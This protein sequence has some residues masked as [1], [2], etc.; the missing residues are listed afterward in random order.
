MVDQK[1]LYLK[2]LGI[3]EKDTVGLF[4]EKNIDLIV[5][6]LAVLKTGSA[7]TLLKKDISDKCKEYLKNEMPVRQSNQYLR[8]H[9]SHRCQTVEPWAKS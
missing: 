6:I 4:F 5:D 7:F 1:A 9:A 2:S 3:F 8:R